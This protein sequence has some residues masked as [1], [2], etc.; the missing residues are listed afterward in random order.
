MRPRNNNY[1]TSWD[2]LIRVVIKLKELLPK[3]MFV[4]EVAD[5]PP[6]AITVP[7]TQAAV[8]FKPYQANVDFRN[9][10]SDGAILDRAIEIIKKFE[11]SKSNPHGG[12]NQQQH[13]WYPHRSL[14]GGSAT[15]AYGHK[16]F[17]GEDF[18]Q[19]LT[20]AQATD[21]LKKDVGIKL[22]LA[23]HKIHNFESLPASTKIAIIDAFY[24]GDMGPKTLALINQN[25]LVAASKEYLN[26]SEYKHTTNNGV[27]KR[28]ELNAALLA[29][30]TA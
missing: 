3:S 20:D 5:V 14:E 19:G 13:R 23:K 29:G 10:S 26:H 21:L 8:A 9:V 11:N 6:P 24:R 17:S 16:I 7:H 28:M 27:K 2:I 1:Y 12:Y 25:N 30:Q 18:S 15:I 4:T 22:N